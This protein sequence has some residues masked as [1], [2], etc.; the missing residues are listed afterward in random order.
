VFRTSSD[1][2]VSHRNAYRAKAIALDLG[3]S[4]VDLADKEFASL[5][6][7]APIAKMGKQDRARKITIADR[8][9]SKHAAAKDLYLVLGKVRYAAAIG[10]ILRIAKCYDTSN[11]ILDS[12]SQV[13]NS[14]VVDC[15]TLAVSRISDAMKMREMEWYLRVAASHNDSFWATIVD[16][17]ENAPHLQ[18]GDQ[19]C[20]TR[21]VI[22]R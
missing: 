11:L 14:T 22:G 8:I 6:S 13:L 3:P 9:T 7:I 18:L 16:V 12:G 17:F 5:P 10:S 20:A 15:S 21:K 19:V 1:P 4:S 2:S